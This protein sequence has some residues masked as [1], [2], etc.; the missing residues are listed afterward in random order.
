MKHIK[1]INENFLDKLDNM[2]DRD[3][4]GKKKKASLDK[5]TNFLSWVADDFQLN[6]DSEDYLG[7][8][9]IS[10]DDFGDEKLKEGFI[11]FVKLSNAHQ[12]G[13]PLSYSNMVDYLLKFFGLELESGATLEE[14]II[15][16][17]K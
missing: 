17:K 1:R 5:I 8:I 6:K 7:F 4:I 2:P 12:H 11:E 9:N 15:Q 16:I 10:V 14:T 13:M 3:F